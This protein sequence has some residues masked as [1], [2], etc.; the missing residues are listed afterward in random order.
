MAK[1]D[2]KNPKTAVRVEPGDTLSAIAKANDLTLAEIKKLNPTLVNDPKY[3]G[4]SLIFSNTK[5]NIAPT[6]AKTPTPTGGGTSA[7]TPTTAEAQAAAEIAD[8]F[9]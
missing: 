6:A 8:L 5:V 2:P 4:G 7:G 9:E 1:P 3:K